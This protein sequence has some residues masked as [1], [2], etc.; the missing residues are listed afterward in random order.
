[1]YDGLS[2]LPAFN[3]DE[4]RS[5]LH[6]EVARLR[7]SI[8]GADAI[9]FSTPEYAGALPGALKNLLDWTIGDAEPGSIY[10]KPVS[11]V[12]AS[13]RGAQAAQQQ[14]ATVL[15]YAHARVVRSACGEIPITSQMI[16]DDGLVHD[17]ESVGSLA[18][19]LRALADAYDRVA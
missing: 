4:D 8:H 5:P 15:A 16:T 3:P 12:N 17:Q 2:N 10:D 9:M 6:P 1:M 7:D 14:L 11:W 13:G 18:A 19:L